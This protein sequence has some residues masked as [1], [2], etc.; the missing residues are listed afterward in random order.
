MSTDLLT[1]DSL[2]STRGGVWSYISAS[3]L[4]CWQT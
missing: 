4:N 1:A 2:A 3:R